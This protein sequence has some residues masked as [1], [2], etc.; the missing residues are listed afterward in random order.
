MIYSTNGAADDVNDH[1][2]SDLR[3]DNQENMRQKFSSLEDGEVRDEEDEDDDEA[4][5]PSNSA[6][7]YYDY[8]HR[9]NHPHNRISDSEVRED[10]ENFFYGGNKQGDLADFEPESYAYITDERQP[11]ELALQRD[12]IDE[13]EPLVGSTLNLFKLS[14][15]N[16]PTETEKYESSVYQTPELNPQFNDTLKQPNQ[17]QN[18]QQE[19]KKLDY[20]ED[21][22]ENE[23]P[24]STMIKARPG[25]G[26]SDLDCVRD[27]NSGSEENIPDSNESDEEDQ[28]NDDII[29]D[30]V[31]NPFKPEVVTEE[32]GSDRKVVMNLGANRLTFGE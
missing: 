9:N 8:R 12:D 7:A 13:P 25:V 14:G 17:G 22:F 1:Q 31:R 16:M 6:A 23:G 10:E 15:K 5:D 20:N 18:Q 29:A 21:Y 19:P 27:D 32:P 11:I 4:E 3:R 30:I 2:N 26:A 28:E 24:M